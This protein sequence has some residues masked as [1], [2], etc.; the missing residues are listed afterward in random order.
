MANFTQSMCMFGVLVGSIVFGFIS[1]RYGRRPGVISSCL[2]QLITSSITPF[3]TNYWSFVVVRFGLGASTAG[4]MMSSFIFLMEIVGPAK[5]ELLGCVYSMPLAIGY[6][7]MALMAYYLRS[8]TNYSIGVALPSIIYLTYV[9][10]MP[11]S[12][13]WLISVGRLEEAS[14]VMTSAAKF[15]NIDLPSSGMLSVVETLAKKGKAEIKTQRKATYMDLVRL[16]SLRIKNLCCCVVWLVIGISFYGGT[17]Y[18]GQTSINTFLSVALGGLVQIP[19]LPLSA[20]FSKRF[21]RRVAIIGMFVINCICNLLLVL[22]DA[23]FYLK[24]VAGSIANA[25]GAAAFSVVYVYTTELFPTVARNMAMGASSTTTRAG[26]MLA[27]FFGEL[28]VLASWLPPIVFGLFPVLGIVACYF[29]P[30]T[31]G[32]QLDD[33]LDES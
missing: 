2:L 23:W 8:W 13:K 20:Y 5:R 27:P 14:I 29:L 12:P 33:H 16:P 17:Q 11:E 32:K 1:D 26:S 28:N 4:T 9:F 15:N 31:K 7:L 6:A 19:G 22:P 25:C 18:F 24:L 3:C 10:Y 30:E 21:G